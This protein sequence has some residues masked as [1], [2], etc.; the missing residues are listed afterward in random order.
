MS[1]AALSTFSPVAPNAW[2]AFGG[3]WRLTVRR[4]F[5]PSQWVGLLGFMAIIALPAFAITRAGNQKFFAP[6]LAVGFYL[7]FL[8]PIFS[9]LAGASAI[10]DELK[11]ESVDYI[12]TRPVRRPALL[13]FKFL[14]HLVC[15]QIGYLPALGVLVAGAI[16]YDVP[17]A[18]AMLPWLLLGQVMAVTAFTG[19]GFLC[20]VLTSR[21]LVI[22]IFYAG[23]V[24]FAAGKIPT[25]LNRVAMTHQIKMML[26]PML[27]WGD[28][29]LKPELP[30]FWCI[31]V[32]LTFAVASVGIA[33]TVFSRQE[34][35]GARPNEL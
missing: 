3:V 12:L 21:F 16:T 22:G 25:Q 1:S 31:V 35:A 9:F 20:G 28:P 6:Q 8:V 26:Q 4:F 27:A 13:V 15:V 30:V 34:L 23:I 18:V 19:F 5:A 29:K 32:L 17:N 10:R 7:M 14:S 33:A 2:H 11:P 24:E